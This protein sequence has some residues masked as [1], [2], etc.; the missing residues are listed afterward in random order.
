MITLV[1]DPLPGEPR[2]THGEIHVNAQRAA[3]VAP[4]D[5][6]HELAL[7]IAHGLNHLSGAR[8]HTPRERRRMRR[9]ELAWLREAAA[10][11]L[12]KGLVAGSP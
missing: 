10:L 7:Y 11:G 9:R 8:D 6:N 2:H 1:F 3:Q 5:A 4:R 12:L